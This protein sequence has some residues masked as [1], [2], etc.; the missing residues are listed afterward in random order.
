MW[1]VKPSPPPSS[2]DIKSNRL[3][4]LPS[5]GV[6]R[7]RFPTFAL[8]TRTTSSGDICLKGVY[9]YATL[10]ESASPGRR[11]PIL[12]SRR[13][14]RTDEPT[15]A[16]LG[17]RS[18]DGSTFRQLPAP[19][20]NDRAPFAQ[21]ERKRHELRFR[22][23]PVFPVS[24]SASKPTSPVELPLQR[25]TAAHRHRISAGAR[26]PSFQAGCSNIP[27]QP[28]QRRRATESLSAPTP[29]TE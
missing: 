21:G 15:I 7:T 4:S 25:H 24:S 5:I 27:V 19:S 1:Y 12:R 2:T 20:T 26:R 8:N 11:L 6:T 23:E 16:R 10:P 18:S 13:P 9:Q 3:G 22:Q 17:L 29:A 14:G 28:S